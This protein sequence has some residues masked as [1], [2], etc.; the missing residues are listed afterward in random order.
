VNR[1]PLRYQPVMWSLVF[2][3]GMYAVTSAKLGL[4]T[5]MPALGWISTGMTAAAALAWS[6]ALFGLARHLLAQWRS[7]SLRG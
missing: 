2:P 6:L 4:A 3:L 1:R 7:R 5:E